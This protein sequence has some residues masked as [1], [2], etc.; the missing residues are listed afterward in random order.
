MGIHEAISKKEALMQDVFANKLVKSERGEVRRVQQCLLQHAG[1]S[2]TSPGA[3][4][5]S[6]PLRKLLLVK[7]PTT[8]II[9]QTIIYAEE[10]SKLNFLEE[11]YTSASEKP[12]LVSSVLEV[13]AAAIVPRGR[14][15]PPVPRREGDISVA[16]RRWTPPTTPR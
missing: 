6:H 5:Y 13:R 11:M 16:T 8:S 3:S 2:S 4:R 7:N 9:D 10:T 12:Y 15:Q 1:R 14:E